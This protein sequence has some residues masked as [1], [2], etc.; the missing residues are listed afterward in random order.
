MVAGID[1]FLDRE[2]AAAD[3]LA[4]ERLARWAPPR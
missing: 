1:A 2:I 3:R 4:A